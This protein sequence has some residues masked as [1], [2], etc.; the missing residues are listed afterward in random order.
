MLP[1]GVEPHLLILGLDQGPIGT[2]GQAFAE[3]HMGAMV[4]TKYCRFHRVV[5]DVRL[6]VTHSAGGVFLKV[7]ESTAVQT[8][9]RILAFFLS[10]SVALRAAVGEVLFY[11]PHSKPS[12][13]PPPRPPRSSTSSVHCIRFGPQ[14]LGLSFGTSEVYQ[15]RILRLVSSG[16]VAHT[17][18]LT[19]LAIPT[20]LCKH[21]VGSV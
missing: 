14:A 13:P 10:T 19:G 3:D 8:I 9:T 15:T 17:D 20:C 6:A 4:H 2:A 1:D 18:T 5:R 7:P 12:P 21:A 11:K 16:L